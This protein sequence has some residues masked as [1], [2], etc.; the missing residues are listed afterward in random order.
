M[1]LLII[2]E[3]TKCLRVNKKALNYCKQIS[4]GGNGFERDCFPYLGSVINCDNSLSVE[5]ICI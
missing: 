2:E 3:K 4:I 1:G 5:I